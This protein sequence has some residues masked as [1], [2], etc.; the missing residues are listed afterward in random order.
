MNTTRF[1]E[2]YPWRFIFADIPTPNQTPPSAGGVTTTWAQGILTNRSIAKTLNQPTTIS[3]AVW[4][5]DTRANETFTDDFPVIAPNNRIIYAFRREGGTPPWKIRAAAVLM[6]NEDQG[7]PDVPL[8]HL[9]AYDPWQYL[10]GRPCVDTDG[11]PPTTAYG[12]QFTGHTGDWIARR[13]LK[14][15]IDAQGFAFVDAGTAWGGTSYYGGTI[16]TT[17]D[18]VFT[19]QQGATVGEVWQQLCDTGTMDIVLTP[20][21]D[22]TRRPGYTHELN[23]YRLA[24]NDLPGVVFG[25]DKMNRALTTI[26][27]LHS[28]TPGDMVNQILYFAGQGAPVG[29]TLTNQTSVD[30]FGI[31]WSTQV[32]PALTL[33]GNQT[34]QLLAAQALRLG[35]QGKRTLTVNPTP[36][37]APVPL[38][39]YDVGDRVGVWTSNRLRVASSA[40]FVQPT[41]AQRVEVIPIVIDDDGIERIQAMI[42]SPDYRTSDDDPPLVVRDAG[43][44]RR[45]SA[46]L[47]AAGIRSSRRRA[48]RQTVGMRHLRVFYGAASGY[49]YG[50]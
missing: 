20:I 45:T 33:P 47:L 9:T 8:T 32:F 46:A 44:N 14:N 11:E 43:T 5:D 31:Y 29:T 22:P 19:V 21:Y 4:P 15:S 48:I 26:D 24:G 2:G 34:P 38:T 1:F 41:Q 27:R 49:G 12:F 25:W 30:A 17:D 10:M 50:T 37:R 16:E 7:D 6:T 18:L 36:E 23:I 39:E 3:C 42:T 40:S 28:G 13:V 35:K